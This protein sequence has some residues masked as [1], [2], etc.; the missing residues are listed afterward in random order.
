MDGNI[1]W[2]MIAM[3]YQKKTAVLY[4]AD[5]FGDGGGKAP[6]MPEEYGT[7]PGADYVK[8]VRTDVFGMRQDA[9]ASLLGVS[10]STLRAWE[11]GAN[12]VPLYVVRAL[13]VM[14]AD[15]GR[16]MSAIGAAVSV[17]EEDRSWDAEDP[18]PRAGRRRREDAVEWMK[19]SP[20]RVRLM[21]MVDEAMEF[22][23]HYKDLGYPDMR[24]SDLLL[25]RLCMSAER[26]ED[27]L[28]AGPWNPDAALPHTERGEVSGA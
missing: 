18:C 13:A 1:S 21:E 12:A 6:A 24:P 4:G 10:P 26:I 9:F 15:P 8:G 22:L 11:S 17:D 14:A 28:S 19:R 23:D 25:L 7:R 20:S 5:G 2:R 3:D 16:A 27:A